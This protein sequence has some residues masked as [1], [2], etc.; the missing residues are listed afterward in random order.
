[1]FKKIARK[2][3]YCLAVNLIF[4]QFK[5]WLLIFGVEILFRLIF[6]FLQFYSPEFIAKKRIKNLSKP[7]LKNRASPFPTLSDCVRRLQFQG[8]LCLHADDSRVCKALQSSQP[9]R[10]L[11]Q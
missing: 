8:I 3:L 11:R 9:Y 5:I 2:I 7:T 10:Q 4:K 1:M 6:I